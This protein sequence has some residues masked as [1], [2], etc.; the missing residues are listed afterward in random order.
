MKTAKLNKAAI[1]LFTLLVLTFCSKD[2]EPEV[3]KFV[4]NYSISEAKLASDLIIPTVQMGNYTVPANYDITAVIQAALLNSVT[5]TP[6]SDSYIEVRKDKSIYLSCKGEN[7][8]LAGTWEELSESSLIL[9]LNATAIP[10]SG[11]Q[12]TIVEAVTDATGISGKTTVPFQK[13]TIAAMIAPLTLTAD[14][15]VIFLVNISITLLKR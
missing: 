10:P 3:S 5:C 6:A 8:I 7:P 12:L 13:T 14:A 2:D 9:N 11:F 15:P 4:G 1:L